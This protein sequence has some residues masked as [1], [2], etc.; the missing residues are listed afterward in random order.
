M[1]ELHEANDEVHTLLAAIRSERPT[2][3]T[4]NDGKRDPE[5]QPKS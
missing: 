3:A 4:E 2:D 1:D 5:T